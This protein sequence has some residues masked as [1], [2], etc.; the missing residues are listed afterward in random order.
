MPT[1][2]HGRHEAD[3]WGSLTAAL[4]RTVLIRKLFLLPKLKAVSW[5]QPEDHV[6]ALQVR[7]TRRLQGKSWGMRVL[8]TAGMKAVHY[9]GI[10]GG[11]T[12][13]FVGHDLA[14][15]QLSD[16]NMDHLD[17][18]PPIQ[19]A[20]AGA[21]GGVLYSL[22]AT[23]IGNF[24]RNDATSG[25]KATFGVLGKGLHFTLARDM[26]GF[27]LYFGAYTLARGVLAPLEGVATAHAVSEGHSL[28]ARDVC[29][30]AT[31][32]G[33]SGGF[34]AACAYQFRSPLDTMY[35]IHIKQRSA[36]TP[37]LS[38]ERFLTSPRGLKAIAIG[39]VTWG[40]YEIAMLGVAR[41]HWVGREMERRD[42]AAF[43]TWC[44]RIA[45]EAEEFGAHGRHHEHE[46]HP[47]R[48]ELFAHLRDD[49]HG[50]RSV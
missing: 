33:L 32:A 37:L 8:G 45:Y 13:L 12:L 11:G 25:R 48:H 2:D 47:D 24:L 6:N 22:I 15:A 36:A 46:C 29:A 38:W 35:K 1:S 4:A 23:P 34:A 5:F 19:S 3:E 27:F 49:L 21:V 26:G 39:A 41:L 16:L 30:R 31:S 40:C 9:G 28:S 43:V 50:P 18:A 14:L 44:G 10:F 7:A 42:E 20:L 17:D